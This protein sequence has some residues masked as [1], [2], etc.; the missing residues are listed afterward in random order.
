MCIKP[1]KLVLRVVSISR[2]KAKLQVLL[3]SGLIGLSVFVN[4]QGHH[5]HWEGHFA[6]KSNTK[7]L[8]PIAETQQNTLSAIILIKIN[9]FTSLSSY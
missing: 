5:S 1:G 3:D 7:E 4:F 9:M 6:K 8:P 2:L